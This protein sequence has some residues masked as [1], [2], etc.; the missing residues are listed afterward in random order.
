VV[1]TLDSV[2][3]RLLR[4]ASTRVLAARMPFFTAPP[5]NSG[6][7]ALTPKFTTR[8]GYWLEKYVPPLSTYSL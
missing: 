2:P 3:R 4:P 1:N 5:L 8:S 7:P 6:T